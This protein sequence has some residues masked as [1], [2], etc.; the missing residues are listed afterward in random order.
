MMAEQRA[1]A[2]QMEHRRA[3]VAARQRAAAP[4]RNLYGAPSSSPAD[5]MLLAASSVVSPAGGRQMQVDE[6]LPLAVGGTGYG[7]DMP[8]ADVQA[9]MRRRKR[10]AHVDDVTRF[11]RIPTK[12][13]KGK[14][15]G[16]V[17]KQELRRRN[18]WQNLEAEFRSRPNRRIPRPPKQKVFKLRRRPH[19]RLTVPRDQ[20]ERM[21]Q[22]DNQNPFAFLQGASA[23]V[24]PTPLPAAKV[25]QKSPA[26]PIQKAPTPPKSQ[27]PPLNPAASP[28]L[29]A[30]SEAAHVAPSRVTVQPPTQ[31]V[32]TPPEPQAQVPEPEQAAVD[33]ALLE[34]AS[35]PRV[36]TEPAEVAEPIV[37]RE[38]EP[39]RAQPSRNFAK[40]F[41]SIMQ[42]ARRKQGLV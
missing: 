32:I 15:I 25:E 35:T 28:A 29:L 23:V 4:F 6:P 41:K 27:T 13:V 36:A 40:M 2:S 18:R 10:K 31:E 11:S 17:S 12:I 39:P 3:Q 24:T 30:F 16:P 33:V 14:T 7:F 26:T 21:K 19:T 5:A 8:P 37:E 9:K 20:V 34:V 22:T 1:R 42:A 38:F